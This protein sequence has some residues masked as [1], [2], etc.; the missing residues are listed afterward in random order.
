MGRSNA[1]ADA[2]EEGHEDEQPEHKAHVDPFALDAFEVTVGRFRKFV[3][4]YDGTPPE[5][6][7]GDHHGVSAGWQSEWNAR[8][9][10]SRAQLEDALACDDMYNYDTWTSA[11]GL[12][13]NAAINCVSWYEA[14]A[15]CVWDRG[16]LPTEVEWEYV[17]AGGDENRRFPW[18][19]ESDM[20]NP[21]L[22][23]T[24]MSDYSPFTPVGSHPLGNGRWGHS[25]LGGG[26]WELVFDAYD[27][28]WY[29]GA[30]AECSRCANNAASSARVVRGGGWSMHGF[31]HDL[32]TAKRATVDRDV[33][34]RSDS[35]GFRCI[36]RV[37]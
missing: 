23:N 14:F 6:G 16:R 8:L 18:G 10:A 17:A 37:E 21:T 22:A 20:T 31:P 36:H 28:T 3:E 11:P 27:A 2:A 7:A 29:S 34:L 25:D 19:S 24:D 9:P 5:P 15:F 30:A 13:E 12:Q 32:R 1:G 26:M 35:V 33:P 4:S